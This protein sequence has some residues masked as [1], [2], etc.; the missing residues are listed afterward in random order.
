MNGANAEVISAV[1][2]SLDDILSLFPIV[3]TKNK[4]TIAVKLNIQ[5]PTSVFISI[6]AVIP[7][8]VY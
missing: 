1:N 8:W 2:K 6:M 5:I 4:K 3:V 7:L